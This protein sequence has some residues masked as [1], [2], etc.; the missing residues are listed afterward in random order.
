MA[1]Q[2]YSDRVNGEPGGTANEVPLWPKNCSVSGCHGTT[3]VALVVIN[4][5]A[6]GKNRTAV[7][8]EVGTCRQIGDGQKLMLRGSYTFVRWVTRCSE[9][10][11]AEAISTKKQQLNLPDDKKFVLNRREKLQA[12]QNES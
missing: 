10:Y 1:R 2:K 12:A 5:P 11:M 6:N 4:N 7:F 9:C 8:S 3:E